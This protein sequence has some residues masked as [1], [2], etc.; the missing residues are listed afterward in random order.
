MRCSAR[1]Q[2]RSGGRGA[3]ASGGAAGGGQRRHQ[4][5]SAPASARSARVFPVQRRLPRGC[6]R[7]LRRLSAAHGGRRA[8]AAGWALSGGH[9]R[10]HGV[11]RA[12]RC[13]SERGRRGAAR[14][15][16]PTCGAAAPRLLCVQLVIQP[17]C[18]LLIQAGGRR[19]L[20]H[21]R[22][23]RPAEAAASV[24]GGRTAS[25][26]GPGGSPRAGDAPQRVHLDRSV[27][28]APPLVEPVPVRLVQVRPH[29]RLLLGVDLEHQPVELLS[30][31]LPQRIQRAL[32]RRP[33]RSHAILRRG[34]GGR[35]GV[36]APRG[37]RHVI[38]EGG[39][40]SGGTGFSR[41]QRNAC[42]AITGRRH[43]AARARGP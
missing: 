27:L 4:P 18:N 15:R 10:C 14:R 25:G 40:G 22:M 17:P 16:A 19:H 30:H 29:A 26:P 31:L 5:A 35:S 33:P 42:V 34:A 41:A 2:Q 24:S 3:R 32:T 1:W 13:R 36:A 7:A 23:F 6:R 9:V 21:H 28:A 12:M 37:P 39:Q 20:A 38:P 8:S 11:A 43:A